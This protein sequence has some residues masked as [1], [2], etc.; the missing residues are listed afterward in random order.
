MHVA[1]SARHLR[2]VDIDEDGRAFEH[3]L[4]MSAAAVF[5]GGHGGVLGPDI[6]APRVG[7]VKKIDKFLLAASTPFVERKEA[8]TRGDGFEDEQQQPPQL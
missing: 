7:P 8:V 3:T 4:S 6:A 1:D 5:L 2:R